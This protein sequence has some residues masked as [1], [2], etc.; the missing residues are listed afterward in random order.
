MVPSATLF[1]AQ[2]LWVHVD[3]K[4]LKSPAVGWVITT[5][6]TMTPDPT[7]T[8]DVL[9][10]APPCAAADGG[11]VTASLLAAD[12]SLPPSPHAASAPA[13]STM[14]APRITCC[15]DTLTSSKTIAN[16]DRKSTRL[17]SSHPSISYA[18]FC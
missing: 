13:D 7:G 14:P 10:I 4:P 12:L 6:P 2:P 5:S 16:P 15:R 1:T 17:N 18:V 3:E 8:S 9:A 11:V